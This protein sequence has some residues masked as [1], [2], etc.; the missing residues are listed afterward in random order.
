MDW[1]GFVFEEPPRR[2]SDHLA[3]Y[4]AA[5]ARLEA[6]GLVY[7]CG[8]T[9]GEIARRSDARDPD[10]AP[11]HRGRCV[12]P[13]APEPVASRLDMT[14]AREH[15]PRELSWRE[16][17]EGRREA[18]VVAEPEAWGDVVLRGKASFAAYHLAVVVDD[19]GQG[20][21]DVIRGRDLLPSTSLHRLLQALLGLE[22]PRY[23][24]HRLV[25]DAEGI[26]MSKSAAST[27]LS[28]LREAG[29]SAADIRVALGFEPGESTIEVV[30]D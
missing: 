11:L 13:S 20:V 22:A 5:L 14:R 7:P 2:Q 23:R 25:L 9:R 17:G 30:L 21:T 16:F 26:K 4:D 6:L 8:C 15:A 28:R 12:A 24:H 19:A 10:G 3:D 29:A 1:L 27:P 18:L